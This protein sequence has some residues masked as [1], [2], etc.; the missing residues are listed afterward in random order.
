MD[1]L[2]ELTQANLA[3]SVLDAVRALLARAE[4]ADQL[5]NTVEVKDDIIKVAHATIAALK[6]ELAQHRRIRF[7]N[8][9][10]VFT[11]EQRDLFEESQDI[12]LAAMQAELERQHALLNNETPKAKRPRAGRQPLP[13]GLERIVHR[14]EPASCECSQCGQARC[15]GLL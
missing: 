1:L 9:S 2:T 12:D 8:K 7:S 6:L 14:H 4:H 13:P 3:P 15:T 10:E 11:S 5:A